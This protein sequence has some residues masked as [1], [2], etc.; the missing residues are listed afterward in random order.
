MDILSVPFRMSNATG[1]EEA[2]TIEHDG[3]EVKKSLLTGEFPVPTI[4]FEL[5]T[6]LEEPTIVRVTEVIPDE[7]SMDAIGFHSDYESDHWTAYEDNRIEFERM[8]APD[9]TIVTIYGIRSE[10]ANDLE[11]FMGDPEVI[12]V[13]PI[14]GP[15]PQ[16]EGQRVD[17]MVAHEGGDMLG[18]LAGNMDDVSGG[19]SPDVESVYEHEDQGHTA[20]PID[21]ELNG[22]T[23]A[24]QL[25]NALREGRVSSKDRETIQ[26]EL[27]LDLSAS[28][29]A[30]LRHIQT[31]VEDAI[32]Y[33][34]PVEEFLDAGG[35]ERF[36][37]IEEDITSTRHQLRRQTNEFEELQEEISQVQ[38]LIPDVNERMGELE[39][40]VESFSSSIQELGEDIET[41]TDEASSAKEIS[42]DVEEDL[43]AMMDQVDELN[44]AIDSFED[45]LEDMQAWRDQLGELFGG[46][47]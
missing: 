45:E 46:Q 5:S 37:E 2:I 1:T 26:Q 13:D 9:E 38:E 27:G 10:D 18:D 22:A 28:S 33:A 43:H 47:S 6:E 12:I 14:D 11:V 3:V 15:D 20:Q 7:F 35:V 31:R 8:V 30:Q 23:L 17:S 4:A 44:A 19:T 16:G 34:T 41:A 21:G 25:A 32:A 36:E 42:N 24:E 39:E 40:E 29:E